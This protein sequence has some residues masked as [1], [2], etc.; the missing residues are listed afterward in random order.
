MFT[1]FNVISGIIKKLI[2]TKALIK[3]VI[4]KVGFKGN[5]GASLSYE[6]AKEF[7]NL[8]HIL[9]L[10][11]LALAKLFKNFLKF[12]LNIYVLGC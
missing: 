7:Q 1:R 6:L 3:R 11:V 8:L 4:I 12:L 9:V 2:S 10:L 5:K